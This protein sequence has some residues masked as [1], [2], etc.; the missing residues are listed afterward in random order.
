MNLEGMDMKESL[1]GGGGEG[2]V[3]KQTTIR[4]VDDTSY[5]V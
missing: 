2:R 4:N 3:S 1:R 5:V